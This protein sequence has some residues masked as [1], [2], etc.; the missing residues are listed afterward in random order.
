VLQDFSAAELRRPDLDFDR[1][2]L[3]KLKLLENFCLIKL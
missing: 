2:Y 3:P 1:C